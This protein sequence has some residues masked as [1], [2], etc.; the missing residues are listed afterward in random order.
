M[1]KKLQ[2]LMPTSLIRASVR[3]IFSHGDDTKKTWLACHCY[4]YEDNPEVFMV[5]MNGLKMSWNASE[6]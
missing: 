5:L 2:Q 6:L 4:Y 3:P 1:E